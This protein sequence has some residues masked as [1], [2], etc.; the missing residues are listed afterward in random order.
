MLLGF[1]GFWIFIGPAVVADADTEPTRSSPNPG[2]KPCALPAWAAWS[3][4]LAQRVAAGTTHGTPATPGL[5]WI[6]HRACLPTPHLLHL[7]RGSARKA[8]TSRLLCLPAFTKPAAMGCSSSFAASSSAR[9]RPARSA[10]AQTSPSSSL[11]PS[12]LLTSLARQPDLESSVRPDPKSR[13][14]VL[15]MTR[16][17]LPPRRL[18]RRESGRST[19]AALG[20]G[21]PPAARCGSC[22]QRTGQA[23]PGPPTLAVKAGTKPAASP[24]IRC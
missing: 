18:Q 17:L 24:G 14:L 9:L 3:K 20:S 19:H 1:R 8:C 12:V 16:H 5:P 11:P 2:P 7:T 6:C 21:N 22:A 10:I 4:A 15:S 23:T 13:I